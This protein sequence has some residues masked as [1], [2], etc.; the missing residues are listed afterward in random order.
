[1]R[2]LSK[3]AIGHVTAD[4]TIIE[5]EYN[6]HTNANPLLHQNLGK[7]CSYCEIFNHDLEVEHIKAQSIPRGINNP[8]HI[9]S[10]SNFLLACGR[11]NGSDNKGS[12]PVDLDAL[13]YPHLNNT[14]LVFEYLEGGIIQVHSGLT[15]QNQIDK[16]NRLMD[17]LCL[18]KYVGNDKY[19]STRKYPLGFPLTDK[20]W[21]TRRS[22]WE[23]AKM[24][25]VDYQN[26]EI[27]ADKIVEFAKQRGCFSVWFTVFSAHRAVREALVNGFRGTARNC[28]DD[29]FN[30]IP[31]NPTNLNDPI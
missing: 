11:C 2:P 29:N 4:G 31:R 3:W 30:P 19:P 24:K 1:M 16:A 20:R 14:L 22:A 10:W 15:N 6:P 28:F 25:L 17:L 5:A 27:T 18:D 7:Y 13:Y 8:N 23:K 21:E 9:I 26:G 12:K